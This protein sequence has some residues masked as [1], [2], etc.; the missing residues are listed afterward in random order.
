MYDD[1][2][3]HDGAANDNIYGAS[4]VLGQ[5]QAHY[6]I[7]A[8][9]ANAARFSPERAEFEFHSVSA[10]LTT[11]NPGDIVINEF[12][13]VNQTDTVDEQNKHE[14]WLELYNNTSSP[15]SMA[16]LYLSDDYAD[17]YKWEFPANAVIPANGFLFIWADSDSSSTG[18]HADFK[19]SSNGEMLIL[20]YKN[21]TVLDSLR[22]G[23]QTA[24]IS[25]SRCP[26][27]TGNFQATASS[28]P[29]YTNNCAF[30]GVASATKAWSLQVYPNPAST[31]FT[32][33]HN[34]SVST[35]TFKLF[36]LKGSLLLTE[37]IS[38]PETSI[39]VASL[40]AGLYFYQFSSGGNSDVLFGKLS[41]QH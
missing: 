13:A 32:I 25:E 29:G 20:S 12:M 3:H 9:N 10:T 31:F 40:P 38:Q 1:G 21:G 15:I 6:Y 11:A 22:F 36:D 39:P 33:K 24:D 14:D 30:N 16:G 34:S 37:K 8:E 41:V 19:L 4:F 26:D 2:L 18:Y 7:Y 28:T 17:P 35:G 23:A 5:S 27:G